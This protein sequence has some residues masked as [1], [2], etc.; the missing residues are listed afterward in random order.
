[1]PSGPKPGPVM[2]ASAASSAPE[3]WPR[4]D[5]L[6]VEGDLGDAAFLERTTSG[7]V[8]HLKGVEADAAH[9]R[10]LIR[11]NI[12]DGPQLARVA[13]LLAQQPRGGEGAAVGELGEAERDQG[14]VRQVG[15]DIVDALAGV[16]A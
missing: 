9:E 8:R 16:Q 10:D 4:A 5:R 3:P 7:G 15:G 6:V 11:E 13:V 1:M 14:E 12:A 2:E